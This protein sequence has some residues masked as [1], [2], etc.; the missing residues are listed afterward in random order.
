MV[1]GYPIDQINIAS[2]PY[3]VWRFV[4]IA[5]KDGQYAIQSLGTGQYFGPYVGDGSDNSPLMS[6]AKTPYRLMY[7]GNGKF[8]IIQVNVKDELDALKADDT[9]HIVLNWPSNIGG[10][11]AWKFEAV[12]PGEDMSFNVMANNSIRIMTLPFELKGDLSLMK[13]NEGVVSTYAVKYVNIDATGTHLGL[14]LK[15]D[16][17]AGEP[18][19]MTVN[20]YTQYDATADSEPIGFSVPTTVIDTSAIVPNGLV[21]TLQ[22]LSI[23]KAGL[24]IFVD[25]KLAI[26]SATSTS[27]AGR[28]GYINPNMVVNEEGAA[29]LIVDMKDLMTGIHQVAMTKSTDQVNVYTIDGKLLKKNVKATEAEKNLNKGIYIVGKKKI[30][31]K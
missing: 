3:A 6:H 2:D 7:Y 20:D 30:A 24:G 14:K 12:K 27:I 1:G 17:E 25:S 9:N 26:T 31:I 4:P 15:N 10:Q 19:I 11:Q 21:G 23:S 22:G 18:F 13:I 29:D 5:G 28:G 16:F 8:K